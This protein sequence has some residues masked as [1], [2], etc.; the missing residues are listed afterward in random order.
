MVRILG[1][2]S[3]E[4]SHTIPYDWLTKTGDLQWRLYQLRV[5][6]GI[7]EIRQTQPSKGSALHQLKKSGICTGHATA[8]QGITTLNPNLPRT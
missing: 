7:T 2:R 8:V 5:G 1:M 3:A 4:G 6:N